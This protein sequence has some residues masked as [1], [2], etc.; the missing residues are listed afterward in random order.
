VWRWERWEREEV[1][2]WVGFLL[3]GEAERKKKRAS[4]ELSEAT[5]R[6]DA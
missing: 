2:V 6:N 3:G 1:W 4:W 5:P